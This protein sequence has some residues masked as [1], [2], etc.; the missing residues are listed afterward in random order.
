M[1]LHIV[2]LK[3]NHKADEQ[4]F[5]QVNLFAERIKQACSGIIVYSFGEN[6][7]CRSEGY[8]HATSSIFTSSAEHDTYQSHPIHIE[9]KSFMAGYIESVIVYDGQI[10]K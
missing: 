6:S 8:T 2:L 10:K 3:F 9:M 5:K 1:F 7:S 4:F